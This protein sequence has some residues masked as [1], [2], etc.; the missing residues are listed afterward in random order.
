M[1][2][3]LLL[4]GLVAVTLC[5]AADVPPPAQQIASAVLS[6]PEEMR[7]GAAVLGRTPEGKIVTL[8]P[9]TNHL[10][11]LASDPAKAT[12]ESAC[13]HKD[14]EPYMAR[15]REMTAQKLANRER[16]DTRWK[17]I[18]DGKLSFPKDPRTL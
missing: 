11:C 2:N 13:Y 18:A 9:G 12:F 1:I 7:A 16:N 8:R 5:S 3:K 10:I 4:S 14:L 6:A 15:G 17:E